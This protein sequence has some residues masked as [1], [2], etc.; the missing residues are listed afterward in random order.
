MIVILSE[1]E[2]SAVAVRN[3]RIGFKHS[4]LTILACRERGQNV[5]SPNWHGN[6]ADG[7]TIAAATAKPSMEL[8]A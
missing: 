7:A 6:E 1:A 5:R 2:G 4:S 3:F 8:A